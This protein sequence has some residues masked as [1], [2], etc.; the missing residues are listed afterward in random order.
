MQ[1]LAEVENTFLVFAEGDGLALFAPAAGGGGWLRGPGATRGRLWAFL[2]G[3]GVAAAKM[4]GGG[5]KVAGEERGSRGLC[6]CKTGCG[7]VAGEA[8]GREPEGK[9]L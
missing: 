8:E 2:F 5:G 7:G 9:R 4:M 3:L 1:A 6:A